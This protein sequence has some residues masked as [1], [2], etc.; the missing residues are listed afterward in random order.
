MD[1]R[2]PARTFGRTGARPAPRPGFTPRVPATAPSALAL[3]PGAWIADPCRRLDAGEICAR[4][5]EQAGEM[6]RRARSAGSSAA[7]ALR[8]QR[9]ALLDDIAAEC[10]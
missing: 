10:G 9:R 6:Q 1:P 4:R 7:A 5:R 2:A 3:G 8:A